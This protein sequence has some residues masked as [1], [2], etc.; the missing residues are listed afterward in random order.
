MSS[1]FATT[2]FDVNGVKWGG[3]VPGFRLLCA[4]KRS[5][6]SIFLELEFIEKA[7]SDLG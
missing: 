6:M 3:C 2:F 1:L 4:H 7:K 5:S